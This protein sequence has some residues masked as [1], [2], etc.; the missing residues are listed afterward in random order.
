MQLTDSIVQFGYT[1]NGSNNIDLNPHFISPV[2]FSQAP[3]TGGNYRLR[4]DSPAINFAEIS[5]YPNTWTKWSA[6]AL[7]ST[8]AINQAIYNEWIFPAL[9]LDADGTA[10][11]KGTHIDLGAWEEHGAKTRNMELFVRE[12]GIRGG[13]SWEDA[14]SDIQRL[15]DAGFKALQRGAEKA[16]IHVAAGTYYPLYRPNTDATTNYATVYGNRDSTFLLRPGIELYGGYVAEGEPLN[17]T[18]RKA[19]FNQYGVPLS[20]DYRVI[21]TGD[22]F[23]DDEGNAIGGFTGMTENAHHVILA[24][25]IPDDGKT[26]FDGFTVTGGNA[27]VVSGNLTIATSS[28]NQGISRSI[29]GGIRILRRG[30]GLL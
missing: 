26:I 11:L 13:D 21:L 15:I 4:P 23:G 20:E 28:G 19:R 8:G 25:D 3:I 16:V 24:V 27:N 6:S 14:S 22:F 5:L 9:G 12:S 30:M 10:R 2:D 1:A 29:G 18:I 17:E 7:F